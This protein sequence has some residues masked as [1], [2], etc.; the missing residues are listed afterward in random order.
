MAITIATVVFP[1]RD[2]EAGVRAW[3]SVFGDRTGGMTA[4]V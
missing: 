4:A 2:F 1:A 3:T